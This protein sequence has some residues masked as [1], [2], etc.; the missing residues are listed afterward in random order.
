MLLET[1]VSIRAWSH[2]LRL[3]RQV[4]VSSQAVLFSAVLLLR[5]ERDVRRNI[6]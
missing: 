3:S 5:E 4:G 1:V 2:L 6:Q